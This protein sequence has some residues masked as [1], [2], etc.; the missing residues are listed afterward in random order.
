MIIEGDLTIPVSSRAAWWLVSDLGTL[1][2]AIPGSSD[3]ER[4]DQGVSA[5]VEQQIGP[6]TAKFRVQLRVVETKP[7]AR[8][9][10]RSYAADR[11]HRTT[12]HISSV[13]SVAPASDDHSTSIHFRHD[14]ALRGPLA[15]FAYPVFADRVH[16]LEHEF[17][18]RVTVLVK[19][20]A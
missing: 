1:A 3:V 2:R 11:E 5:L 13:V 16:R 12:V 6:I 7:D 10:I 14:V 8:I 20:D 17:R 9:E 15:A 4:T 19:D 18:D